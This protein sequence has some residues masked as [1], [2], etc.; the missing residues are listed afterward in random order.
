MTTKEIDITEQL[1]KALKEIDSEDQHKKLEYLGLL[2]GGV[3]HDLNNL[4]TGI[5]GNITLLKIMLHGQAQCMDCLNG[6]ESSA[7]K[8]ARITQ[9]ILA[10]VRGNAVR[11]KPIN[12]FTL[13]ENIVKTYATS[14]P[15]QMQVYINSSGDNFEVLGDETKL[16][17]V[18]LNLVVNSINALDGQGQVEVFLEIEKLAVPLTFGNQ[19]IEAGEYIRVTVADTGCGMSEEVLQKIFEPFFT[20]KGKEGTGLGLSI[21]YSCV[22]EHQGL[23]RVF[24]GVGNG[25]SFQIYLPRNNGTQKHD[26]SPKSKPRKSGDSVGGV[27]AIDSLKA[28]VGQQKS[29]LVVDD[30]ETVRTVLQRSLEYL[31]YK[32]D[33][34]LN[35]KDALERYSDKLSGYNLVILDMMMPYMSGE[36]TFLAMKKLYPQIKVMLISGYSNDDST[37]KVLAAGAL[38]F[39]QKPFAVEELAAEV[40]KCLDGHK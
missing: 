17:Q 4:L 5:L 40:K 19:S 23:V 22:K 20:T 12:M 9:Q 39:I 14:L 7:Q 25:T 31:G 15:P 11:H 10:F 34:A 16:H 28:D 32:V 21:V 29:I 35:G 36:E 38:S 8:S 33:A 37:K 3:A 26:E 18:L 1:N 2:S 13:A 30:E 27:A 6:I 24:S